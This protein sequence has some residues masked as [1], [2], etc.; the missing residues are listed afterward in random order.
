MIKCITNKI[1]KIFITD[2][3]DLNIFIIDD[4]VYYANLTKVHLIKSGYEKDNITIFESGDTAINNIK[5][6]IPDFIILDQV[7]SSN[8]LNGDDV[9]K[10]VNRDFPHV[11]T[12]VVS[13]QEDVKIATELMKLGAFDYIVK[14]EMTFFNLDNTMIKMLMIITNQRNL[15]KNVIM[16]TLFILL[17]VLSVFLLKF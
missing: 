1:K 3:K 14:N 6:S 15:I 5:D 16:V 10:I 2:K 9:L 4:N 17:S 12:I 8:G 13:G 7:L 11:K